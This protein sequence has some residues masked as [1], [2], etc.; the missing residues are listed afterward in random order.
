MS[1]DAVNKPGLGSGLT[2]PATMNRPSHTQVPTKPRRPEV[3]WVLTFVR[4]FVPRI[5]RNSAASSVVGCGGD[6]RWLASYHVF[7]RRTVSVSINGPGR[8][9]GL[10]TVRFLL[11]FLLTV[12]A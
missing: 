3:R 8:L 6:W 10:V 1:P 4:L 5:E 7:R 12:R 11:R 2:Y 9:D